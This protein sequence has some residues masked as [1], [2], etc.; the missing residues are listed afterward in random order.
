LQTIFNM[1]K[2]FIILISIFALY[3]AEAQ[4]YINDDINNIDYTNPKEYVLG[5]IT[6]SG[7]QFLD[8]N[9]LIML[10]GLSVG[11]K[12]TVPGDKISKAIENLWKQGLFGNISVSVVKIHEN[13]IFLDFKIEE[14]PRLTKFSF[15]G[16]KKS[17][18][19][20]IREKIKLTKGDVVTE[21]L[22]I[23]TKDIIKEY[24][25]DKGFLF[26]DVN[27]VQ[28]KDSTEANSMML[29]INVDKKS[30]VKINKINFSGNT[31]Y[32]SNIIKQIKGKNEFLSDGALKRSMKKTKEKNFFRI[33]K[34]SKFLNEEFENDKE[35]LIN[36]Y[37]E[38]GFRDAS[39][40]HD[41]VYK[42]NEKTVNI[43]L[44]ISEGNRYYF[45][46]I[47][48]VGNTK[49]SD[50]YLSNILGIKKGD[51]YNQKLLD[52]K[53]FM[54][55][56]SVDISSLYLDD[57]YLFFSITPVEVNVDKDSIDLEIRIYEGKQARIKRIIINGNT[58]THDNV[59]MREIRT[60]PGQ[61]F[62]RSDIIRSQ[63]ELLQLGYFNQETLGVNPKPDPTD[64][65]VDIEYTVEETSSD[66][67]EL[68]GGWG[69]GRVVGTL[70][71]SFNNFSFKNFLKKGAWSPVPSGDGQKLSLRAQS[72]G[73]GYQSYNLSFTEPWFGGKKPNALSFSVYHSIQSN[74]LA[75]SDENREA[76]AINGVSIGLGKRLTWPD[77]YF[78]IYHT[79]GIQNYQVDNYYSSFAFSDGYSNNVNYS[80]LFGRN[81][82]DAPIYPRSGSENVLSVQLTPP[83]SLLSNKDY[84]TLT[85][86]EKFKWIE[87]HKWKF[88][89]SW[90]TKLAG[91]LVLNMR[92]KFGFLGLYNKEVGISPFER[93]YLGGDGLSGF[94]LDGR[95]IIALRGYANNTLT[96]RGSLGYIGGTIY[97]KYTMELRY[98]VSLNPMA[99]IF[100]LGFAEAGNCFVKFNDFN[101][102]Q[103]KRSA[104]VG[105][106]I[107]LPMFGLLG[108]DWGYGFDEIPGVPS[109]NKSQ[110]HFSIGQSID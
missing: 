45:R 42:F 90:Y 10:T 9:I 29:S 108:L 25:I 74:G 24:F 39:I 54:S 93:F 68:S 110:F 27:I 104:G 52:S 107:F 19:D 76:I 95:E 55:Q 102:F 63:R 97:N 51:I 40:I 69:A 8:N 65:T 30:K 23:R 67:I 36:K 58:K 73:I 38:L 92:S 106:R 89:T 12:I 81:S 75:K 79:L 70:G 78:T 96:P 77:D 71:V 60:K 100:V 21:N 15:T 84:S 99:T 56:E 2:F 57:G 91:N 103:V 80:I 6:I 22:L 105:V 16:I 61:L 47:N 11:D 85:D 62:N 13:T 53:L 82:I 64:G 35:A 50:A 49:Y 33:F 32:K 34:A 59:I 46:N 7:V 17:E 37:N 83:F 14:K 1:K 101:A 41:S 44:K 72:Y 48:W 20:N 4:T 88:N 31:P 3:S 98:P 94:S 26:A 28:K 18:A 66:Q 109:A 87:Y 86:Q 5:G 43:D